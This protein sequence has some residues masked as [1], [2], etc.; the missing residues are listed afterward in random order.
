MRRRA[1]AKI[2]L[3]EEQH[4]RVCEDHGADMRDMAERNRRRR[5]AVKALREEEARRTMV[6]ALHPLFALSL[7]PRWRWGRS[8]QAAVYACSRARLGAHARVCA[9]R[10]GGVRRSDWSCGR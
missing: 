1:F 10:G 2:V 8:A 3:E 4:A 5:W 6:R 7:V 9:R